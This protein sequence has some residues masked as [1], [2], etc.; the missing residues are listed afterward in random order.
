[1][2]QLYENTKYN[3]ERNARKTITIYTKGHNIS[4]EH[5]LTEPLIIDA[6][7]EVY[8]DSFISNNVRKTDTNSEIF[9]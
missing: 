1:M 6:F 3:F 8:I 4:E 5:K 2:S 7:S 9:I